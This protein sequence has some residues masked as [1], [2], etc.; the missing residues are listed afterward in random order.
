MKRVAG[1]AGSR[2]TRTTPATARR[3]E[4][5]CWRRAR[6]VRAPIPGAGPIR[7]YNSRK[8]ECG[9]KDRDGLN[10]ILRN[11]VKSYEVER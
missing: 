11:A 4:P 1:D 5:A 10:E 3:R 6:S 9:A 8:T 2:A 7:G